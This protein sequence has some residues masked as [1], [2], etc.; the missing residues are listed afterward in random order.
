MSSGPDDRSTGTIKFGG[1][2]PD[3]WFVAAGNPSQIRRQLLEFSGKEDEPEKPLAQLMAEIAVEVQGMYAAMTKL[4]A[5]E[6]PSK[7]RSRGKRASTP[8]ATEAPKEEA[9][10]DPNAF[11][12]DLLKEAADADALKRI[13]AKNMAAF[14]TDKALQAAFVNRK[15]ELS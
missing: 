5:Q 4:G 6:V 3:P 7:P 12:Y 9:P 10:A 13:F 11:L 2:F 14:N 8:A 15:K 1:D